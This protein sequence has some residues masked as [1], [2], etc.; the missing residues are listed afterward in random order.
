MNIAILKEIKMSELN[1]RFPRFTMVELNTSV[2]DNP[3]NYSKTE[4]RHEWR[5][6]LSKNTID[7][8]SSGEEIDIEKLRKMRGNTYDWK[9]RYP[10]LT[11]DA[12]I[13]ECQ[14]CLDNIPF[15]RIPRFSLTSTYD[16]ILFNVIIPIMMDRIEELEEKCERL[17]DQH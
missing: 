4:Y 16:E 2:K 5:D 14:N 10:M 12:L 3:F 13:Y 6:A 11:N 8:I 1:K 9:T 7:Y 15:R 17:K